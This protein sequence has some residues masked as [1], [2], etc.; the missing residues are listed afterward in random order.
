MEEIVSYYSD[1]RITLLMAKFQ[2]EETQEKDCSEKIDLLLLRYSN[3]KPFQ[4]SPSLPWCRA[5][6]KSW[7]D[8]FCDNNSI[9]SPGEERIFDP[10][11]GKDVD[12]LKQLE[13]FVL[14]KSNSSTIN[15]RTHIM[16]VENTRKRLFQDETIVVF[17]HSITQQ[18]FVFHSLQNWHCCIAT[19]TY[20]KS[21]LLWMLPEKPCKAISYHIHTSAP[22][23]IS[24]IAMDI[25]WCSHAI[26][27]GDSFC[28]YWMFSWLT[29]A[30]A[31][32]NK[33]TTLSFPILSAAKNKAV[34][35]N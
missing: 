5:K 28:P 31:S 33:R 11:V 21:W 32:S 7:M 24:R 20:I 22:A 1:L 2:K 10:V 30:P 23:T 4:K 35:F 3:L 19:L 17:F 29:S 27:S 6:V 25:H 15:M 34:L 26:D 8:V 14:W 18:N 9:N 16:I 13:Y 12:Q